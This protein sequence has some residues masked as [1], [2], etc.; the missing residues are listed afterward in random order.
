MD[1]ATQTHLTMLRDAIVYRLREL[2]GE[3]RAADEARL[4]EPMTSVQEVGDRKDIAARFQ[5]SA[6]AA[7]AMHRD[8][9]EL[10]QFEAAL[11]RMDAGTYGDCE[12]C[13]EPI[14]LQR[15]LVQPA[16]IRCTRCQALQE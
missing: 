7:A 11:H 14:A 15:L 6:S 16:A 13:G 5:D 8:E 10:A 3:L 4:A 1:V 9:Q 2:R 12:T